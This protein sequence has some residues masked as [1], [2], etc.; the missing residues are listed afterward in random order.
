MKTYKYYI[1]IKD[2]FSAILN[3]LIDFL[4]ISNIEKREVISHNI[5]AEGLK[6][7]LTIIYRITK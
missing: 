4:D 1:T 5:I 2:N 7:T 3:E 6:Y